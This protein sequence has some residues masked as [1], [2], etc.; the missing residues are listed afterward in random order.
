MRRFEH[1]ISFLRVVGAVF[2]HQPL[3][4]RRRRR[5]LGSPRPSPHVLQ[6]HLQ[7]QFLLRPHLL[8]RHRSRRFSSCLRGDPSSLICLL[9]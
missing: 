9:P 8:H 3:H 1:G 4:L 5:R 2:L 6:L 7:V